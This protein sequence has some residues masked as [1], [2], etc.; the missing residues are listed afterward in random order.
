MALFLFQEIVS[1]TPKL[2]K[3]NGIACD[4]PLSE[5]DFNHL[6]AAIKILYGKGMNQSFSY[7]FKESLSVFMVF[8]AVY[9]Y[10]DRTFWRQIEEYLGELSQNRRVELYYNFSR[11]L[12]EYKL[13]ISFS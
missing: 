2:L 5:K 1:A 8:C 13:H 7:L 12:E 11:V 4:L 3:V 6:A 9:E 10:Q